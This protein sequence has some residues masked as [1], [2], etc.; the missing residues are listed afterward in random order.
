[1]TC[2]PNPE[3]RCVVC[4]QPVIDHVKLRYWWR[5]FWRHRT[6]VVVGT[7]LGHLPLI[8]DEPDW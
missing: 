3:A 2:E 1:M 4:D 7:I 6:I 8:A 5:A